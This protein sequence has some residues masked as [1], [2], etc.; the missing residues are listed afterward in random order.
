[1]PR[2]SLR[3]VEPAN[4]S[5]CHCAEKLCTRAKAFGD[6]VAHVAGGE[7][8][9]QPPAGVAQEQKRPTARRTARTRSRPRPACARGPAHRIDQLA[10][11]HRRED[12]ASGRGQKQRADH[13]KQTWPPRPLLEQEFQDG[14]VGQSPF[15]VVIVVGGHSRVRPRRGRPSNSSRSCSGSVRGSIARPAIAGVAVSASRP[16]PKRSELVH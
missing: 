4:V 15:A 13:R 6:H 5:A 3:T 11:Q 14:G 2:D 8:G 16:A 7:R 10:G 9:H 12:V 1:M